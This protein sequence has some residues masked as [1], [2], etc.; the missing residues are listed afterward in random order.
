MPLPSP[1]EQLRPAIE[2]HVQGML[3]LS[4]DYLP[5]WLVY[6]ASNAVSALGA[7]LLSR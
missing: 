4:I 1:P 5:P 7:W 2:V 6:L 3:H